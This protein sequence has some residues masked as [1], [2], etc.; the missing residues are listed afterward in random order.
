MPS[1]NDA[2]ERLTQFATLAR[3]YPNAR[4][5]FT[6]GPLPN[7]P[8]G[9]PEANGVR[10]LLQDLGVP[11][12]RVTFESRSLTTR[13]NATLASQMVQPKSGERWL[14]ITSAWHMPRSIGAFRAVGWN[15]TAFPVGYKT[16]RQ[17]GNRANRRFAERLDLLERAAH[18]WIG[19]V[20]YRAR[21][22]S[23]ELFPSLLGQA[24]QP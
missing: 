24:G 8:D 7:R 12:E 23:T 20:Y 16:Y 18:E 21:G 5:V 17:P 6:G 9:P 4:L 2:G 3:Q 14:L 11:L 22:W 15:M 10:Q 1:L 13:E 19:L